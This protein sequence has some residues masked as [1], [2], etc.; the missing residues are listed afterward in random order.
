MTE[1]NRRY[2]PDP[3]IFDRTVRRPDP[4]AEP[5]FEPVHP[6]TMPLDDE[7]DRRWR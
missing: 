1:R 6:A 7:E 4:T 2:D 3:E 5:A